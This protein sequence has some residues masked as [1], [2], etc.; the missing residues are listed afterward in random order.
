MNLI[1]AQIFAFLKNLFSLAWTNKQTAVII[2]MALLI[3]FL[4]WQNNRKNDA[5]DQLNIKN[6]TLAA[7]LKLKVNGNTVI[8]R[9]KEK[10]VKIYVPTEGGIIVKEPDKNGNVVVV[11][12]NKGFTM[13]PGFGAYY[14]GKFDGALDLKLAFWSRY[15]GGLGSTLDSPY[16]WMSRHV[17]DLVPVFKPENIEFSL[18][19]GKPYSNFSNS[20]FLIGVRTNF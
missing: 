19:Y 5:I 10:I 3:A 16:V 20:I 11:V 15:S 17:D 2:I 12:K 8:Y 14:T 13:K 4:S 18:G 1:L 7:D 9:D 6:N